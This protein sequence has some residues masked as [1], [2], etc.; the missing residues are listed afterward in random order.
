MKFSI[1]KHRFVATSLLV[2]AACFATQPTW[3]AYLLE[4]IIVVARKKEESLQD[5][6]AT[7]TAFGR[8]SLQRLN[9]NDIKDMTELVPSFQSSQN[10]SGAGGSMYLRGIGSNYVEGAF[11][12]TIAM[13][14]DDIVANSSRL[15]AQGNLDIAQ[16]EILK[17]PQ[18]L[19]FGKG[20]SAGVIS[21]RSADPGDEFE[22][23]VRIA[24][25]T[26]EEGVTLEGVLSGPLSETLGARLAVRSMEIDQVVEN[27]LPGVAL[28]ERGEESSDARLTLVWDPADN[29]SANLKLSV[30]EYENDGPLSFTDNSCAGAGP[31]PSLYPQ[32]SALAF[33]IV[34]FNSYDCV[35]GDQRIQLGDQNSIVNQPGGQPG[36]NNGVPY[37]KQELNLARLKLVWQINESLKLTSITS[38]LDLQ[39]QGFDCFAVDT[40]GS[41]C[42][43]SENTVDSFAQEL[44]LT[45]NI[46]N[47]LEF[48]LGVYYQDRNLVHQNSQD[49]ISIPVL[50]SILAGSPLAAIDPFTGFTFDWIKRHP[51]AHKTRS[52]FGSL[53]WQI[54][55][56]WS[57][58]VG[59]RYSDEEKQNFYTTPFVHA[60][61]G[62]VLPGAAASSGF[63]VPISFDDTNFSPEASLVYAANDQ[64][65]Y[66]IAYKTGFKSGGV[67]YSQLPFLTDFF[68]LASGDTS[69]LVFDSETSEGFEIGLKS[70]LLDGDLLVNATLYSYE[71][72]NL[73]NQQL[74][75]ATFE[76]VTF[77]AGA[78]DNIGLEADMAYQTSIDGFS[79]RGSFAYTDT[80]YSSRFV[81]IAGVDL[82]GRTRQNA[83][84]VTFNLGADYLKPLN[85]G[86]QAYLGAT[87]YYSDDYTTS[88]AQQGT[89][90]D[91]VQESYWRTDV[92]ASIGPQDGK[93]EL[94]LTG[95]NLGDEIYTVDTNGRPG[96]IPNALGQIDQV[97][98]VNRGRQLFLEGTF[99][100]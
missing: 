54:N 75:P 34:I 52:Y 92:V 91:F 36:N 30:S 59:G 7:I 49:A 23:S 82:N 94:S 69:A 50:F 79:L 31:Q 56:Q 89:V 28:S 57:L 37:G 80:E 43:V 71:Y 64:T 41:N 15:I 10:G 55:D 13:N 12:S 32:S 97:H 78:V 65:N 70:Y 74:N 3:A 96:S 11:D 42:L 77:N 29:F 38:Q 27:T 88:T 85:N 24:Y 39:E 48:L 26:E 22:G 6:P 100:F 68:A 81:N 58:T 93:W 47:N 83:P 67:S 51:T 63:S 66:Y 99:R 25:E 98:F 19:Y 90:N 17:G 46:S 76:F 8:E 40:N 21:I 86:L 20:A 33:P 53:E 61:F 35:L 14:F 45:G 18:S 87:L 72:D 9:I 44:R 5:V 60:A 84:A 73:Q 1:T 95:R 4:E 16:I 2:S 62:L